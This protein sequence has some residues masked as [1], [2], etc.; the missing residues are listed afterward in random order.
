[1]SAMRAH[2]CGASEARPA[3]LSQ[4][5]LVEAGDKVPPSLDPWAPAAEGSAALPL[6]PPPPQRD[7][8]IPCRAMAATLVR[9]ASEHLGV[10]ALHSTMRTLSQPLC[11]HSALCSAGPSVRYCRSLTS[12]KATM[13]GQVL[14]RHTLTSGRPCSP[15]GAIAAAVPA[16]VREGVVGRGAAGGH[17]PDGRHRAA[18]G[19]AD[20]AAAGRHRRWGGLSNLLVAP[21]W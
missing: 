9:T 15:A 16:A 17:L 18:A 21:G 6:P 19:R 13:L 8:P 14:C 2:L 12:L 3:P 4:V 5:L 7:P 1:M 10:L 20:A 11:L